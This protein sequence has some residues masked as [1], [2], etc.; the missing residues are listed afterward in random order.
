MCVVL[1]TELKVQFACTV[2][3]AFLFI[4]YKMQLKLLTAIR[5]ITCEILNFPT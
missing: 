5:K 4:F 3:L 1:I 2:I